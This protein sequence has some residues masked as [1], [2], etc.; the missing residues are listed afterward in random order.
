MKNLILIAEDVTFYNHNGFDWSELE[1]S[2]HANFAIGKF[3]RGGSTITQQLA[4]NI[5]LP[6]EKSLFR[7]IR[8]ALLLIILNLNSVKIKYLKST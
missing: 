8:E 5:Y 3:A 7:K 4:K 1:N 2:F 6:F